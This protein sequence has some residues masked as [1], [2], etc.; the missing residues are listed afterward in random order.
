MKKQIVNIGSKVIGENKIV[1]TLI[2]GTESGVVIVKDLSDN[3]LG[4]KR[5]MNQ[6]ELQ[7]IV[8]EIEQ[9]AA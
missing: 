4:A 6:V 5:F 9:G 2:A 1:I 7:A 3:L 8:A